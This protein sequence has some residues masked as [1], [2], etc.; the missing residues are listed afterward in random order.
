[1]I[2]IRIWDWNFWRW[3]LRIKDLDCDWDLRVGFVLYLEIGFGIK[4]V[5]WFIGN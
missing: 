1:M 5:D 3:E 2:G 4:T